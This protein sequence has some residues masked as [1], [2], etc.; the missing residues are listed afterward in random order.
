VNST[1]RATSDGDLARWPGEER[2]RPPRGSTTYAIRKP[3]AAWIEAQARAAGAELERVRVLDVG[4][5]VKPYY[6]WFAPFAEEYVGL[7]VVENPQADINGAVEDL[8]VPDGSFD[9]VLCTQVLEHCDDPAKAVAEL[10][11]VCAPGGRVLASTHGVYPYH[12]A[13][14]DLWRWTHAG[15][16]RLFRDNAD[17]T[18][19]SIEPG[20]GSMACMAMLQGIFAHLL[21]KQLR[22]A[23]LARPLIA[24][25]N[26][27]GP[28]LDGAVRSLREPIPGSLIANY[29]V[30]ADA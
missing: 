25:G 19:L 1:E 4:C 13:P 10:R 3:L 7:D 9:L 24:L 2:R 15:L 29:H 30:R 26:T 11:R 12:P 20:S 21:F 14:N 5:G 22:V 23:P 18:A 16:E 6:P 8:P 27:L 17:W 28:L